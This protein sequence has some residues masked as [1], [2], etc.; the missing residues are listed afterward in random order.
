MPPARLRVLAI[1][2]FPGDDTLDF[3]LM[4]L[5]FYFMASRLRQYADGYC[6]YARAFEGFGFPE[7]GDSR[8]KDAYLRIIYMMLYR[9]CPAGGAGD[10]DGADMGIAISAAHGD[11]LYYAAH[12]RYSILAE[13]SAFERLQCLPLIADNF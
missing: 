5:L 6:Y 4:M 13:F 3:G 1:Y 9:S 2:R 10:A 8:Q 11:D 12:S 7:M